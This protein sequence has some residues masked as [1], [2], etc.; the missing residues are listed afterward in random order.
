MLI[1]LRLCLDLKN[2]YEFRATKHL[3]TTL[4]RSCFKAHAHTT[5]RAC[6]RQPVPVYGRGGGCPPPGWCSHTG[7]PPS[8]GPTAAASAGCCSW[9]APSFCWCSALFSMKRE[10]FRN[11]TYYYFQQN[12]SKHS[13]FEARIMSISFA[14]TGGMAHTYTVQSVSSKYCACCVFWMYAELE[15]KWL[16]YS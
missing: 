16:L 14:S 7:G 3:L 5:W 4:C 13:V 1:S 9:V 10:Q 12:T 11:S 2:E 6:W 15:R 8:S